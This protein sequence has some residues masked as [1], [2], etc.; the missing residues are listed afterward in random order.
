MM[1]S[2]RSV[3]ARRVARS[4]HSTVV[5]AFPVLLGVALFFTVTHGELGYNGDSIFY[6]S[7]ARTLVREGKLATGI[8]WSEVMG[9]R[10]IDARPEALHPLTVF[11][12][13]YPVA[14][15]AVA[16]WTPIS[17]ATVV[18]NLASLAGMIALAGRLG[19]RLGGEPIGLLAATLVAV[20]PFVHSSA[21]MVWSE[22]LFTTLSLLALLLLSR[23]VEQPDR[24]SLDLIGASLASGAATCTRY[25]GVSLF[26]VEIFALVYAFNRMRDKPRPLAAI[27]ALM[28]YPLTMLPLAFR[29]VSLTGH[30]GGLDR[31]VADRS[32][33]ANLQDVAVALFDAVPLT[34]ALVS[35][36]ADSIVSLCALLAISVAAVARSTNQP[37][38]PRRG[39]T[40][41]S[42]TGVLLLVF[43][44]T[45]SSLLV[46]LGSIVQFDPIGIRLLLP[47]LVCLVLLLAGV[48]G[49]FVARDRIA[50][51]GTG[52]I[53]LAIVAT[54]A[55]A[56][57]L[58]GWRFLNDQSERER[59]VVRW[60]RANLAALD[61]PPIA[62]FTEYAHAVHFAT[63]LPVH[64]LPPASRIRVLRQSSLPGYFLFLIS[65]VDFPLVAD[66]HELASYES[67]LQKYATNVWRG[68]DLQVWCIS[69]TARASDSELHMPV[70][71]P[72]C[73]TFLQRFEPGR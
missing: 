56:V 30:L 38:S 24:R 66:E 12:P 32:V 11:A 49:S 45:Y 48:A 59:P 13:G 69:T 67:E 47:A 63:G 7:A 18:V 33:L 31:G 9:E 64:L 58:P 44:L 10:V 41:R 73:E 34:R 21:R 35:G 36:P 20:L 1:S 15:A 25:L 2:A 46:F 55:D 40:W 65:S 26:I 16:R 17:A 37:T 43:V 5:A 57:I 23:W 52:W 42:P 22:A 8:S 3:A 68:T 14:V 50:L 51:L 61:R 54:L 60:A 62:I 72:A 53:L 29:N 27:S 28:I 4:R 71:A 39:S 19:R 70:A 6:W